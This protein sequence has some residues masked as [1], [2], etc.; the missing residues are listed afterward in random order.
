MNPPGWGAEPAAGAAWPPE[1]GAE[2]AEEHPLG[3]VVLEAGPLEPLHAVAVAVGQPLLARRGERQAK[4]GQALLGAHAG[5][6][7]V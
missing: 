7:E 6:A 3:A 2:Q 1:L 5:L 4:E